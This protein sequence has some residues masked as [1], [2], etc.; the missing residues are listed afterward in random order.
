MCFDHGDVWKQRERTGLPGEL[1]RMTG[2]E[3]RA[4]VNEFTQDDPPPYGAP[5]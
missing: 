3:L 2:H 4:A 5:R 1:R